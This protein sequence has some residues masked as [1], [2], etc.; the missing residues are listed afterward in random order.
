M[1]RILATSPQTLVGTLSQMVA[2]LTHRVSPDRLRQIAKDVPKIVLVTGDE[3]NLVP[4]RCNEWI[5]ECM[6]PGVE[7]EKW[8]G[9]G[10]ALQIQR[11]KRFNALVER[12]VEESRS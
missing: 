9:T 6:G 12:V 8:E 7:L 5:K 3:D 11:P 4:T 2:G 10:H 1:V